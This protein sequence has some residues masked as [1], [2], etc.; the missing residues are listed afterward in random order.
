MTS[1]CAARGMG[2]EVRVPLCD[3]AHIELQGEVCVPL[4]GAREGV[5]A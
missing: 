2:D 4:P 5:L 1:S 3:A